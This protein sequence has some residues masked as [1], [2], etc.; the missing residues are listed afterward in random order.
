M[1]QLWL[2]RIIGGLL[3]SLLL[4]FLNSC[5]YID[6]KQGEWIFRPTEATW[7]GS[8][9]IPSTF[10]E[11]TIPVGTQ[12]DSIHAWWAPVENKN[13]PLLLYLHGARWNLTGSVSRIPR[14]NKMGFSVLAID[15]RGFGKSSA[16]APTEQLAYE[17]TEAAWAY[18]LT[19]A[20]DPTIRKFIFGHSLGGAMATHLA[21]KQPSADGLI[22]EG[23]F[24]NIHDMIKA[25]KFGFLPLGG[26]IT[27][28]FDNLDR[29]DDVSIPVLIAHGTADT[30][31]P[32]EMSEK[33]FAAA[34]AK[35]RF[36]KAD[37]GSHH[38]L[39]SRYFDDYAE[40]IWTHFDL[41]RATVMVETAANGGGAS[42]A[43]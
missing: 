20:P 36:F 27:Q 40:A 1:K 42:G 11:H 12:G 17:D 9:D 23:T 5:A 28:R 37:G 38:N 3:G 19:L 18:L 29:I 16:R 33:L 30:I 41:R 43:R 21:L 4:T 31:V 26:I 34:K 6:T 10:V 14:W 7:W 35:K 8:R 15:Y 22:L 13:A 39:T 24:T 25:S 32:Y 2:Q